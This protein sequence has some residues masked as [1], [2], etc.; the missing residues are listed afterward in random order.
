MGAVEAWGATD[1][2]ALWDRAGGLGPVDRA[3]VLAQAAGGDPQHLLD[4]PVG[5][6]HALLLQLR[7]GLAGHTIEA[8]AGCPRCDEMVEL[9]LDTH[10]LRALGEQAGT[11]PSDASGSSST[12][13]APGGSSYAV[14][15][16]PP[17]PGDLLAV[18]GASDAVTALRDRC[19][20]VTSETGDPVGIEVLDEQLLAASEQRLA[21][22]DPLSEI[23]L[24][25][26]C[27]ACGAGFEA[28]VDVAA[29]VWAE[30]EAA[31]HRLLHEVDLLARAYGWTEAEVLGL[32][33]T[34][35]AAYLRLVLD[36]AP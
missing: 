29:F 22:A 33:A 27:P 2:V 1:L 28:E 19:L 12:L 5:L 6:T 25:T 18:A 3:L 21:A 35:R 7:E 24:G 31:A 16:R 4:Q 13:T 8:T 26:T 30:V 9:A 11:A 10:E 15:G 14:R 36:G 34:R 32:S 23:L 20:S 17:T